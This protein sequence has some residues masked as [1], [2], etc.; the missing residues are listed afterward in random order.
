MKMFTL[1]CCSFYSVSG[2][3]FYNC[4][5]STWCSS[6]WVGLKR[7][8]IKPW[9]CGLAWLL[10]QSLHLVPLAVKRNAQAVG[11]S[12]IKTWVYILT[13][14]SYL[15]IKSRIVKDK[16]RGRDEKENK[17]T[18]T[19][20]VKESALPLHFICVPLITPLG[21]DPH[22][23][24]SAAKRQPPHQELAAT[25]PPSVEPPTH[26]SHWGF[27]HNSSQ[28]KLLGFPGSVWVIS[29]FPGKCI[30][31]VAAMLSLTTVKGASVGPGR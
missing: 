25:G 16:W 2:Y 23:H 3:S 14:A 17:H 11:Q 5:S 9:G 6:A 28:P 26:T 31:R 29:L 19:A 22:I 27:L 24:R 18:H 21:I 12:A 15:L 4:M 8:R 1:G 30:R 20:A 10:D 13:L 7:K